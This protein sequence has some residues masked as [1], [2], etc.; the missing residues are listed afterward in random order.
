MNLSEDL[1]ARRLIEHHSAD[2]EK[3]FETKRT[4]YLGVDPTADSM[5]AGNLVLVL[6][7]RRLALAGHSI[8]LGV[9]GGTGMIGDPKEKGE[10]VLLDMKTIAKNKKAIAQQM[11]D[12]IGAKVRIVDN[13][14]WLLKLGLL[15]FLREIGKHFTIN[16]LIKRDIIRKRIETP[17][18]SISYT[19]FTYPLL[20]GFDFLTL[21]RNY[22]CD[23]QIGGTDQWTNMLSGVDL[24]RKVDGKEAFVITTPLITDGAGKKFGKSEGNAIW[25][26]ATK[27]TPFQFY[28][29]WL[30]ADDESVVKYLK[31]FTF[32]SLIEIDAL[33]EMHKR[34]PERRSAQRK[35]ALEVT[36]LVHGEKEAQRAERFTDVL[37]GTTSYASLSASERDSLFASVP[38]A[39]ISLGD[40]VV[41]TLTES[42]FITSKSEAKRLI[43]SKG[44]KLNGETLLTDRELGEVDFT[45]G[46]AILQKGKSDKFLLRIR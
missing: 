10:R 18:E 6:I 33:S 31:A 8:I 36:K 24:I 4:V 23:L 30:S 38:S 42:G 32:L 37:F 39:T 35:L 19:E 14:D 1:K 40:T 11:R 41:V 3:I 7:L 44:I 29:F 2:L 27:T 5:H 34:S 13:A 20:Q 16:D 43:D 28:Q 46:L 25:L 15:E 21:N 9:G 26:D 12:V 45:D 22:D 17:D